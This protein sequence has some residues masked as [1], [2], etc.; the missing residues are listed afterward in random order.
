MLKVT[1][2]GSPRCRK[3]PSL[4]GVKVF[5]T[6]MVLPRTVFRYSWGV[7]GR[8]PCAR[9]SPT[10]SVRFRT[11]IN[12]WIIIPPSSNIKCYWVPVKNYICIFIIL[13]I[14]IKFT[15]IKNEF[16]P[17]G[18]M[19]KIVHLAKS[20][21]RTTYLYICVS[22]GKVYGLFWALLFLKTFFLLPAILSFQCIRRARN[23]WMMYM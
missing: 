5:T 13:V 18:F 7:G 15:R 4:T 20:Q 11:Y 3:L 16:W 10:S 12:N 17:F 19:D 8:T 1:G 21:L 9:S 22:V 2:Y 23:C 6:A 14:L